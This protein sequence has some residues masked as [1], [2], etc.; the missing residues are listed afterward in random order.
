VLD[1]GPPGFQA[2]IILFQDTPD[3]R[4][5]YLGPWEVV[6]SE[7]RRVLWQGSYQNELLEH[8]C[9]SKPKGAVRMKFQLT[10]VPLSALRC[11]L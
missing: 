5:V 3:E 7:Q 4:V 2:T 8:Y 6:G 11:P 10:Q 9:A 1:L